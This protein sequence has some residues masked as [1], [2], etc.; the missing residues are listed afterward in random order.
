MLLFTYFSYKWRIL[1]L[2]HF[3]HVLIC[4]SY[5]P[6]TAFLCLPLYCFQLFFPLIPFTHFHFSAN[7]FLFQ[8]FFH[9]PLLLFSFFK[10]QFLVLLYLF[11]SDLSAFS[12]FCLLVGHLSLFSRSCSYSL[13]LHVLLFL[14]LSTLLVCVFN[15]LFCKNKVRCVILGIFIFDTDAESRRRDLLTSTGV[16]DRDVKFFVDEKEMILQFV[17]LVKVNK[18]K[19]FKNYCLEQYYEFVL[20]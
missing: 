11:H 2:F 20:K 4:F 1:F 6:F 19:P 16:V 5:V 3:S 12:K 13:P 14:F 17:Q 18:H 9:F 15:G 8:I 10:I 7:L